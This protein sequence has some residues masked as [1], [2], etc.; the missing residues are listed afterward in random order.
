V[1]ALRFDALNLRPVAAQFIGMALLLA[2]MVDSGIIAEQACGVDARQGGVPRT[3]V[4]H[5]EITHA[6]DIGIAARP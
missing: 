2:A 1:L 6:N 3:S 4:A 5:L